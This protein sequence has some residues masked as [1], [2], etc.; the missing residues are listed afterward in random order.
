MKILF[1]GTVKFSNKALQKLIDLNAQVVGV[2]T[3]ENSKFNSDFEDLKPLCKKNS[4][5]FRYIG[6]NIL[7]EDYDWIKSF[8]PD[9]IFCFGWSSLL[10]NDI[11]K[12][13]PRVFWVII[14]PNCQ[15]IEVAI[16]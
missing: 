8:N 7:K 5:P 9:I 12:L 6:K 10:K 1:I 14:P 11:L 3:K 2:C 4:I 15:K 13:A 16:L